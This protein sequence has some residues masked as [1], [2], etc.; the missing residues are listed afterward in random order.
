MTHER[1]DPDGADDRPQGSPDGAAPEEMCAD[2]AEVEQLA[3]R[4]LGGLGLDIKT[5]ARDAGEA[6]EADLDGPDRDY[7]LERKGEA[8]NALQ[9][10]LNRII[11]RG[12][13]GR[14]IH[15]DCGG[16]RRVREDEIVQIAH[17]TAETVLAQGEE[18]MLSP[19]NPYERRL[20]HL[21]LKDVEGVETRSVGD[22][23]MKRVA[24]F[25]TG[26]P[27]PDRSRAGS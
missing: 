20:V 16:Y 8:L 19:L 10:L 24:I 9:Y 15:I 2:P 27:G 25:P 18:S 26:S 13:R 7:L 22:G 21:A 12:R 3:D 11:Y 4:I 6:I 14:K 17:R 5:S 1:E 23:F